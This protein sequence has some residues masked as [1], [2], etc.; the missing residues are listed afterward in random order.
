MSVIRGN[1][2]RV[3]TVRDMRFVHSSDVRAWWLKCMECMQFSA[4]GTQFVRL[5][6]VVGFSECPLSE[7]P[8]YLLLHSTRSFTEDENDDMKYENRV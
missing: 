7:V 3:M 6:E 1:F 5:R 2:V 4:G 8:L